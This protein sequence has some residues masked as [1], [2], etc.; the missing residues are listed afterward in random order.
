MDRV[1][2]QSELKEMR[3]NP[4]KLFKTVYNIKLLPYQEQLLKMML[5]K[6][7]DSKGLKGQS[8]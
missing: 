3:D 5:K 7:S 4:A 1:D 2:N 6:H 8:N